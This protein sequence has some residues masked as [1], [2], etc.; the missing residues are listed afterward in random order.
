MI[1]KKDD[2]SACICLLVT[3]QAVMFPSDL[4]FVIQSMHAAAHSSH[5]Y[6][7]SYQ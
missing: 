6:L 3:R 5:W 1:K 4:T 7:K 2:S